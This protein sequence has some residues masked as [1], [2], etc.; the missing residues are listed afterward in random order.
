MSS[1]LYQNGVKWNDVL[2]GPVVYGIAMRSEQQGMGV[3]EKSHAKMKERLL[4]IFPQD[5]SAIA[6]TGKIKPN[7]SSVHFSVP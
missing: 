4:H 5:V 7:N 1:T 2:W 6:A 3:G